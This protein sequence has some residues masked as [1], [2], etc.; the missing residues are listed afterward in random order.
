MS[1]ASAT[2]LATSESIKAYVDS[3]DH[4]IS[5]GEVTNAKL[6]NM[7][8]NTIK[9]RNASD[10]GVPSDIALATT[11][12]LIGDGTGFTAAALSGD[13]TMANTGAV[14]VGTLNQNTTGSSASCTGLS[15]TATALATGRAIGGT[16]FNGT[17]DIDIVE[18]TVADTTDTTCNVALFESATGE[19]GPKSDA[20]LTYNAGT[21][22]LTATAFAGPITGAVTGNVTGDLTGDVTGD[23]SG[24]AATATTAAGLSATLAVA[25]GGTYISSYAAGDLLYATGATTLAKLAK[26]KG[27]KTPQK[28]KKASRKSKKIAK[29]Q[30]KKNMKNA[31]KRT[32][33]AYLERAEESMMTSKKDMDDMKNEIEE[34]KSGIHIINEE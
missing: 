13:V 9:V 10:A 29:R 34:L 25:S 23:V 15:A 8:G 11:Q 21:G 24:S 6:A 5:D 17:A 4:N 31:P 28:A 1:G 18:I 14:T 19:L 27:K 12:I 26:G 2:T 30:L 16:S 22:T 20:G 7:A 3:Q 32:P 33:D